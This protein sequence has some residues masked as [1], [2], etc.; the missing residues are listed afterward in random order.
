MVC[1]CYFNA[2]IIT[3]RSLLQKA[4]YELGTGRKTN[5]EAEFKP[6]QCPNIFKLIPGG[7]N[8][9]LF[10]VSQRIEDRVKF[11]ISNDRTTLMLVPHSVTSETKQT[12]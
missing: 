8:N 2:L 1:L 7:Q 9:Q 11:E 10:Y 6:R 4:K 3:G 12:R 5:R